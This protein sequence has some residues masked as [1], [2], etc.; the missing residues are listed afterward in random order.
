MYIMYAST[1]DIIALVYWMPLIMGQF[2][3]V[4]HITTGIGEKHIRLLA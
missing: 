1:E 4:I 2:S 3:Y